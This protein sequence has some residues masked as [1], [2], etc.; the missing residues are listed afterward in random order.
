V[1]AK[2]KLTAYV[3]MVMHYD[4]QAF[5]VIIFEP[6]ELVKDDQWCSFDG[7]IAARLDEIFGGDNAFDIY[8]ENN[9]EDIKDCYAT[10]KKLS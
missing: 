1:Q 7:K 3:C 5:A 10:R 6:K 8:C 4:T 9:I 2:N